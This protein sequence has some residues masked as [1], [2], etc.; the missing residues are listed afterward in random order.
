MIIFTQHS[1]VKLKQRGIS[2]V[3]V[4]KTLKN[5]DHTFNS[6]SNR[7]VAFKKLNHLY[8]KVVYKKEKQN[9]IV[10]TQYWVKEIKELK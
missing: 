4:T 5:P 9:F 3:A 7:K 8:L 6:Y 10:I 2:R 1:F